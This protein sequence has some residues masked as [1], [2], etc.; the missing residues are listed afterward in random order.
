MFNGGALTS[1]S[2]RNAHSLCG[3]GEAHVDRLG[4]LC[5]AGHRRYQ[6]RRGQFF[7]E[8]AQ[9]CVDAFEIKFR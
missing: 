4:F 7:A 5:P 2:H 8:Q 3:F 9:A 6:N 1:D